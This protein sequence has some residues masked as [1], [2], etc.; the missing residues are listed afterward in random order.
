M[1]LVSWE[2]SVITY[3]VCCKLLFHKSRVVTT[4]WCSPF[5]RSFLQHKPW[6]GT[7]HL[8]RQ[9]TNCNL[10][11]EGN[12][13]ACPR[14]SAGYVLTA[15]V[16]WAARMQTYALHPIPTGAWVSATS[17]DR[18]NVIWHHLPATPFLAS[19]PTRPPPSHPLIHVAPASSVRS[20]RAAL[21]GSP[22][23]VQHSQ[24]ALCSL[25]LPSVPYKHAAPLSAGPS[26]LPTHGLMHLQHFPKRF[27]PTAA[28][29]TIHWED[30]YQVMA[31]LL[32]SIQFS[33]TVFM[34]CFLQGPSALTQTM[35]YSDKAECSHLSVSQSI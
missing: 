17:P 12:V 20:S 9:T 16:L 8:Q 27:L 14:Y 23:P 1:L 21:P 19:F 2:S 26:G 10:H 7:V 13:L 33:W 11:H 22:L 4:K 28:I 30:M 31:I 34:E 3:K 6:L 5:R 25:L 15:Q 29:W 24:Q 35:R 18:A 32:F